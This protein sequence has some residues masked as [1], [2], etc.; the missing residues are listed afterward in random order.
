MTY[1]QIIIAP[2]SHV[3]L[4]PIWNAFTEFRNRNVKVRFITEITKENISYSK[5]LMKIVELRHL[6]EIKGNFGI[7]DEME[8]RAAQLQRK[9]KP[10]Q[11]R[12]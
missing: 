5:Q 1:A 9:N 11:N 10:L 7:A 3:E 6:D 8:Y 12:L 2:S 4:G